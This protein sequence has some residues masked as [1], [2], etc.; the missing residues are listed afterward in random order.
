MKIILNRS[1]LIERFKELRTFEVEVSH[2]KSTSLPL[3]M[4]DMA[5]VVRFENGDGKKKTL[6]DRYG[7]ETN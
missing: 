1:D 2:F 4:V 6:K 5:E 3:R 7:H